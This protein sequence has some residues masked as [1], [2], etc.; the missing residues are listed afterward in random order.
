MTCP[1]LL[2]FTVTCLT[3][4]LLSRELF[5]HHIACHYFFLIIIKRVLNSYLEEELYFSSRRSNPSFC[6]TLY[7]LDQGYFIFI[8]RVLPPLMMWIQDSFWTIPSSFWFIPKNPLPLFYA[9]ERSVFPIDRRKFLNSL[10]FMM[11]ALV[12]LLPY[13]RST[14]CV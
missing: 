10:K 13:F 5:A 9:R 1:V 3:N 8:P 14:C 12:L 7:Y 11:G 4:T 2:F 6:P